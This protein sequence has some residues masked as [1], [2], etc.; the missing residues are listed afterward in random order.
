[1]STNIRKKKAIVRGMVKSV[2][3]SVIDSQ[4]LFDLERWFREMCNLHG[5]A[6]VNPCGNCP[7]SDPLTTT[8]TTSTTTAA[9]T[10]S[11]TTII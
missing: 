7:D 8:T 3:Q 1:M 9:P 6:F 2:P 4:K 5:I 10:T 11:T